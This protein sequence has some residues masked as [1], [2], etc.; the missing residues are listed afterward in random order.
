MTPLQDW[1]DVATIEQGWIYGI[2]FDSS[3]NAAGER[4]IGEECS[5]DWNTSTKKEENEPTKSAG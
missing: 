4:Q 1:L 5:E 3:R 2:W